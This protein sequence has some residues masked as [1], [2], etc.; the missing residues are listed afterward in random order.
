MYVAGGITGLSC[1]RDG[2]GRIARYIQDQG[3]L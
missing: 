2:L 1:L 3:D